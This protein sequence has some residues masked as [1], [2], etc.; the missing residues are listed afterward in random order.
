MHGGVLIS[1]TA[2]WTLGAASVHL[3]ARWVFS[4]VDDDKGHEVAASLGLPHRLG[5]YGEGEL[6][7]LRR[8]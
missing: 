6:A 8:A 7:H 1:G 2:V 4:P 3:A 5:W